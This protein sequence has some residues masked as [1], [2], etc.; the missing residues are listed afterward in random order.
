MSPL[1]TIA[2][3]QLAGAHAPTVDHDRMVAFEGAVFE[4]GTPADNPVGRYGDGWY[5]NEQPS[6][7]VTLGAYS[8]DR[9][10]V[11]WADYALFLTWACGAHCSDPRMDVDPVEGGFRARPGREAHPATWVEWTHAD[12]YCRWAGKRLPT[13]SEWEHAARGSD[14]RDWPWSRE[15]G[16][17]CGSTPHAYDG[18][19]CGGGA[20]DHAATEGSPTAEGVTGLGGNVAEWT[21]DWSG[22][23]GFLPA[24][25]PGGPG[26]GTL[27]VVRGG[28][29]LSSRQELKA[30]ARRDASPDTRA[31]DLGFR[32]AWDAG[33]TDPPQLVR[34]QLEPPEG[35]PVDPLP[36][37]EPD[38]RSEIYLDQLTT[39]GAVFADGATVYVAHADGVS[40]VGA[41]DREVVTHEAPRVSAWVADEVGVLGVDGEAGVVWRVST[42]GAVV[43]LDTPGVLAAT[44]AGDD[45]VWTDGQRIVRGADD[46]VAEGRASVNALVAAGD[47]LWWTESATP[48]LFTLTLGADEEP[49]QR[50][51]PPTVRSPLTLRVGGVEGGEVALTVGLPDWPYS[52]LVCRFLTAGDRL[53]CDGHSPPRAT[54]VR[55]VEGDLVWQT[56]F[57]VATLTPGDAYR[58]VGGLVSPGGF[59][60]AAG[61]LWLTD[62]RGGRL[63]RALLSEPGGG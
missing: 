52:A 45:L 47:R 1:L 39:P 35:D 37:V 3:L 6:H 20:L 38:P 30:R 8:L 51:G 13:E 44:V 19:R 9:A 18:G 60:F 41:D 40:V 63:L 42:E 4:R 2:L 54:G 28:G 12:W 59:H 49:R 15:G 36:V 58:F 21:S 50:L 24:E 55:L 10:E 46:V 31:V 7:P 48:A 34:G 53:V 57:G 14:D 27:K 5:V 16:P 32:C 22:P 29:F 61:Q 23:Y 11:S 26:M 33:L 62:R 43:E 25:D 56:Q 17:Q